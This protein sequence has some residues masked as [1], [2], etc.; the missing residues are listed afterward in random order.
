MD[1]YTATKERAINIKDYVEK[2]KTFTVVR[3]GFVPFYGPKD[4]E[5]DYIKEA[6]LIHAKYINDL[7]HCL[8]QQLS[9]DMQV[10][11]AI[12]HLLENSN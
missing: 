8:N 5:M 6:E 10:L 9:K 7:A 3:Q 2:L 4:R 12:D 11:R 1:K